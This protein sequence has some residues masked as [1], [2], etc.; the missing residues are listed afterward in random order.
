MTIFTEP[1]NG[2]RGRRPPGAGKA[3]PLLEAGLEQRPE[4]CGALG[5]GWT[6]GWWLSHLKHTCPRWNSKNEGDGTRLRRRRGAVPCGAFAAPGGE[7]DIMG[8]IVTV[9][10]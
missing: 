4:G 1:A 7:V 9:L 5:H 8:S 6:W 3:E 10:A 2:V